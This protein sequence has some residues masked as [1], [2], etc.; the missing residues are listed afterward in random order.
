VVVVGSE[1]VV[2]VDESSYD[3]V[4]RDGR[5]A[6]LESL[7]ADKVWAIAEMWQGVP[8]EDEEKV[9]AKM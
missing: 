6:V 9:A 3:R 8:S 1:G 5:G 2:E 7:G 4:Y